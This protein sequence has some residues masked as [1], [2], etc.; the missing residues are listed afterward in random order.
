[1]CERERV[2]VCV[3]ERECVCVCE[4]ER[5]S[6]CVWV[7]EREKAT[8]LF[9]YLKYF[10]CLSHGVIKGQKIGTIIFNGQTL[11][12]TKRK[13]TKFSVFFFKSHVGLKRSFLIW[14]IK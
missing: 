4:R 7:R 11:E 9:F 1:M 13:D 10:Y 5:E 6:V 8:G 12:D 3:R 14:E 2:C